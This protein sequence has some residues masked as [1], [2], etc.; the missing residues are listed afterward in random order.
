MMKD[1]IEE[2]NDRFRDRQPEEVLGRILTDYGNKVALATSMS[3]ED[4]VLIHMIVQVNPATR[5]FTLDTGRLFPETYDLIQ[6]TEEKYNIRIE[7]FFP[8]REKVE[9]M[10]NEKGINLFLR[11]I[12][13]RKLCCQIRKN[14]PLKKALHGYDLWICGL[15]KEQSSIR[16]DIRLFEWDEQYNILKVNPLHNWTSKQM[17]DY[18]KGNKIPYNVL[19][20]KGFSSIGCQ[21]CTRAVFPDEDYRSGRWWWEGEGHKE[22]GIHW[23]PDPE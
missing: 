4:Q 22:C 7:I 3:A 11:S 2:L 23:K 9:E 19:H 1:K 20:D 10:V 13:N 21:P 12:E 18:I 8:D 6:R 14:D 17:W 15:R 5:V 16:S